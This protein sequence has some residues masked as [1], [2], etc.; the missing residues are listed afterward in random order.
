MIRLTAALCTAI[1]FSYAF[2][3]CLPLHGEEAVYTQMVRL[4]VVAASDAEEDQAM[5]YHV[6]DAVLAYLNTALCDVENYDAVLHT[7]GEILPE[8][9]ESA[10]EVTGES[11]AVSVTLG[12]E[13]YPVRYYDNYTLP[14]GRYTSLRIVL[15]DGAGRNWWCVVFPQLCLSRAAEKSDYEDF[16]AAGFTPEQYRMIRNES[17]TKYKIRFRVLEILSSVFG[18][19]YE[20]RT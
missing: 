2:L 15:G 5:K 8:I 19:S 10:S 9:R 11:C 4:H 13:N 7:L 1:L 3:G 20:S 6:R 17:G 16:I 12:K 18:F 14:A